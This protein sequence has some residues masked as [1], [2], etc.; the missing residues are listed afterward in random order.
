MYTQATGLYTGYEL[1]QATER[2]TLF[3]EDDYD[4]DEE[5]TQLELGQA[6]HDDRYP[7]EHQQNNDNHSPNNPSNPSNPNSSIEMGDVSSSTRD[8]TLPVGSLARE[9]ARSRETMVQGEG[10]ENEDRPIFID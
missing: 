4:F 7:H 1:S 5:Y 9:T 3:D 8:H 10:S 2:E 6:N